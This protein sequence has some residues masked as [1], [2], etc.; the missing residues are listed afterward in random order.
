MELNSIHAS[1]TVKLETAR[2]SWNFQC[3]GEMRRY[4][5]EHQRRRRRTGA[6]L[7]LRDE[8]QGSERD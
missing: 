7:T 4:W 8:S 6:V 1:E 3:S 2:G 5:K